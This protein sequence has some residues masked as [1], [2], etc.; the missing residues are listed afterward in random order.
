MSSIEHGEN[1]AAI[2]RLKEEVTRLKGQQIAAEKIATLV[3]MTMEDSM[4]YKERHSRIKMLMKKLAVLD[5]EQGAH[6]EQKET[7]EIAGQGAETGQADRS[8]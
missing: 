7:Q 4:Q 3:G 5:R 2:Q 1:Q 8:T 6:D